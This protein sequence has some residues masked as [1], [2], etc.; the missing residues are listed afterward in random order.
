MSPSLDGFIAGP[1]DTPDQP[2]GGRNAR[3]LHDWLLNGPALYEGTAFVRPAGDRNR[4]FFD[5]MFKTTGAL[6]CGRRTYDLVNGWNGSHPIPN[7]PV[8]VLTHNPPKEAPKGNSSFTFCTNVKDAVEAA[9]KQ[10]KNKDVM[11]HGGASTT[12]AL[13]AAGL[14]DE[15]RLHVAPLILGDGRRLFARGMQDIALELIESVAT[16]QAVHM[17]YRV[18]H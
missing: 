14:I 9:K 16:K 1:D 2:L 3:R 6:L 15:L 8:V 5:T 18:L 12:D 4:E 7:L 11:I 13:L 10:A 17:R